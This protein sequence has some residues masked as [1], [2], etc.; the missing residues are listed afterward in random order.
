MAN[1]RSA[2]K[3]HRQ[4]IVRR[5]RNRQYRTRMRTAIKSFRSVLEEKGSVE[6]VTKAFDYAERQIRR[7]AGKGVIHT[8]TADRTISRLAKALNAFR[9]AQG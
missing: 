3:R 8:R 2:I 4:S 7:V 5:A 6:D 1:H 9:G